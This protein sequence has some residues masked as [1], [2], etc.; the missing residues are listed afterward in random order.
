MS[1]Y[2]DTGKV[3]VKRKMIGGEEHILCDVTADLW[4]PVAGLEIERK[5]SRCGYSGVALDGHHIHGRKNSNE[6]ILLCS[7]CH[8]E[9]HFEVGYK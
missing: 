9:Y 2:K 6:T 7:N 1:I 8:R 4:L 3:K 5:C